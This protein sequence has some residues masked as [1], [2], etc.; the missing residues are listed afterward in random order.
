MTQNETPHVVTVATQ[1]QQ[2]FVQTLRQI[3][4]AAD[5]MIE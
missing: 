4:F 3:E 5:L 2:I 1:A